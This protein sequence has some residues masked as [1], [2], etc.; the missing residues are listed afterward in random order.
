MSK[1]RE[2]DPDP[3]GDRTDGYAPNALAFRTKEDFVADYLRERILS[4]RL[5]RGTRLK[6]AEIAE[7]IRF[8]ITPVREAFRILET[9]G[10]LASETHRGVVVAPFN[11][12]ATREISELR[13]VLETRL[14]LLAMK[15]MTARDHA[16]LAQLEREFEDADARQEWEAVRAI[17]YRFH[18][19]LY[20]LARQPQ[21]LH[22]VQVLWAKY[23][24]DLINRI[25]GRPARAATEH[26]ELLAA[27][28]KTEPK[29]VARSIRSHIDIGWRE[30]QASLD[31]TQTS[32]AAVPATA[33]RP[34]RMHAAQPAT[35][36]RGA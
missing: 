32:D 17:N 20:S 1:P 30:L 24:F 34:R 7:E 31:G 4:G 33:T 5:P 25:G 26:R 36:R 3:L 22:F 12:S 10:Y 21:T 11:A 2:T 9:E 16:E 27:L 6:Q 18:R 14:A 35:A 29:A 15:R 19:H 28:A 13:I 8:S 23:P